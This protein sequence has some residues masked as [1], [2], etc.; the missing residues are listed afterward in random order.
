[1]WRF[2]QKLKRLTSTLSQWFKEVFG[3]IYA[4][5]KL[6]EE[7]VKVTEEKLIL[8]GID[9]NR[10]EFY[11]TQAKYMEDAILRQKYQLHWFK[12]GDINSSYFYAFIRGK[13]RIFM[14]KFKNEE[15]VWFQGDA[16][17]AATAVTHFQDIYT[18]IAD[19]VPE[20]M[21]ANIPKLIFDEKNEFQQAIP[22]LEE[23]KDVVFS[24][25]THSA[26]G[27]DGMDGKFFQFCWHIIGMELL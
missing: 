27:P 24:I 17:I 19:Y 8:N 6:Y 2:Q 13:R 14:H 11:K 15:G 16:D 1:M 7:K 22:T 18:G 3:D 10:E 21:L 4:N 26:A 5:V 9:E 25:S 23:V 12:Y 20:K